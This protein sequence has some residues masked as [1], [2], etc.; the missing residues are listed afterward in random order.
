VLVLE[1]LGA[2]EY[3]LKDGR[4]AQTGR[5]ELLLVPV[6]ESDKLRAAVL[7]QVARHRLEQTA[8]IVGADAPEPGRVPE[9]CSFGGEGTPYNHHL[10]PVVSPIAAPRG[11]FSPSFGMEAIDIPYMRRQT[12]AFTDLLLA[13]GRMSRADI[14]GRVTQERAQRQAGAPG[15]ADEA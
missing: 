15:C 5:K 14:A 7:R 4:L 11:L 9:H 13:M 8:V 12:L 3:G 2:L 1:H 6:S 10:L